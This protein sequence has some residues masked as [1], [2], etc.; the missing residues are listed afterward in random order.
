MTCKAYNSGMSNEELVKQLERILT[1]D[2]KGRP[3]KARELVTLLCNVNTVNLM[4]ALQ[5]IGERKAF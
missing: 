2:G 3:W 4:A 5:E 1:I